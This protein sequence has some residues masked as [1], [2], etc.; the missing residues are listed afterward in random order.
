MYGMEHEC[1]VENIVWSSTDTKVGSGIANKVYRRG[2][3]CCT[4]G[5]FA[6]SGS[7]PGIS[8]N[9]GDEGNTS[10][11]RNHDGHN[12]AGRHPAG[13]AS[14]RRGDVARCGAGEVDSLSKDDRG[15]KE[16]TPDSLSH[17]GIQTSAQ[18]FL[19]TQ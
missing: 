11:R 18:H 14:L 8:R 10:N 17:G 2:M 3:H 6:L 7:D 12:D 19:P 9:T 13:G 5:C 15:E 1:M 4:H 16:N